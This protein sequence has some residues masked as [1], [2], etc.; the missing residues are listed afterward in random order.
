MSLNEISLKVQRPDRN[1][2]AA[3]NARKVD[4]LY[5]VL[6]RFNQLMKSKSIFDRG[7]LI[8]L[9]I[10]EKVTKLKHVHWSI[11]TNLSTK[12]CQSVEQDFLQ[13]IAINS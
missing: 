1:S 13:N 4:Q 6:L 5:C 9:Y 2:T 7:Y 3:R 8:Q 10:M 12:S 11:V